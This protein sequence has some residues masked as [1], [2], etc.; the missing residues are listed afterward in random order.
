MVLYVA[1]FVIKSIIKY[2]NL[3]FF[4]FVFVFLFQTVTLNVVFSDLLHCFFHTC[5]Y[6]LVSNHFVPTVSSYLLCH[7]MFADL[8]VCVCGWVAAPSIVF[9]VYHNILLSVHGFVPLAYHWLIFVTTWCHVIAIPYFS[10]NITILLCFTMYLLVS[11]HFFHLSYPSYVELVS[12]KFLSSLS[13][14]F[15]LLCACAGI[16]CY[17]LSVSIV[18]QH[19]C[20]SNSNTLILF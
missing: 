6:D 8:I 15:F 20:H 12:I 16:C 10:H 1:N 17:F 18:D 2:D 19:Q 4:C 5:C 3:P 9:G 14:P 11:G 7:H 13:Y